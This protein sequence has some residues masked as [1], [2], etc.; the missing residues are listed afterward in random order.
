MVRTTVGS[1]PGDSFPDVVFGF[2][3][4]KV[5]HKLETAM[6]EAGILASLPKRTGNGLRPT[7]FEGR[8][9]FL[10]PTCAFGP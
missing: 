8:L 9:D 4:A 10:G 7:S 2:L 6:S 1:R 5:L 3:W